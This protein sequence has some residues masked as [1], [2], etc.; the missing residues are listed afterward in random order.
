M[1]KSIKSF[2]KLFKQLV[3]LFSFCIL[4]SCNG[5]FEK[6]NPPPP[7]PLVPFQAKLHPKLHWGVRTSY[8]ATGD[9]LRIQ[10]AITKDKIITADRKC[11]VTAVS[12]KNGR[13]LWQ[14]ATTLSI[15]GG[16]G[17]DNGFIVIGSRKGQI[18]ALHEESG[19]I[20]WK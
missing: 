8:H 17:A 6:D 13:L 5:F 9:Y 1:I 12:K 10:P 20:L 14:T 7:A 19:T 15:A 3:F 11:T 4:S 2:F 18:E 16:P